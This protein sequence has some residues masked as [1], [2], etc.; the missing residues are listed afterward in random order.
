[1]QYSRETVDKLKAGLLRAKASGFLLDD[2]Q[3]AELAHETGLTEAQVR[4]WVTM[5]GVIYRPFADEPCGTRFERIEGFLA[6]R[7]NHFDILDEDI[8]GAPVP[9]YV[10]DAQVAHMAWAVARRNRV[11]DNQAATIRRMQQTLDSVNARL[12]QI[13][14]DCARPVKRRRAAATAQSS[15]GGS[16]P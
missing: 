5:V 6:N 3:V 4:R 12:T 7:L 8:D 13:L 10:V 2:P 11:I 15:P 16:W 1:M 9:R 14:R